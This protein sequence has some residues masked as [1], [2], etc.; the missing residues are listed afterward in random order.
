M[1]RR[2]YYKLLESMVWR[3]IL[4]RK[5]TDRIK[6]GS[7]LLKAIDREQYANIRREE[8]LEDMIDKLVN[9]ATVIQKNLDW[10]DCLEEAM[11]DMKDSIIYKASLKRKGD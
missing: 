6:Y 5:L 1:N 2:H 9:A 8:I 7:V 11:G 10:I 3:C 4:S